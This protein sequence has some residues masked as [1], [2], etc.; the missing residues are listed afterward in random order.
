MFLGDIILR[1]YTGLKNIVTSLSPWKHNLFAWNYIRESPARVKDNGNR[2]KTFTSSFPNRLEYFWIT[3]KNI[4]LIP[5]E[6]GLDGDITFREP[7][8]KGHRK[9]IRSN[10]DWRH[11]EKQMPSRHNR[12]DAYMN[13]QRL[14]QHAQDLKSSKPHGSLC[15]E[16]GSRPSPLP[17]PTSYL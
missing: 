10:G 14:W 6:E 1:V 3:N 5:W 16:R 4:Q 7:C 15:T 12:P 11:Q 2:K 9:I 8:R 13:P 17:K